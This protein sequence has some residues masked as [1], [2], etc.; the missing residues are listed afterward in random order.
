MALPEDDQDWTRDL[1]QTDHVCF[2]RTIDWASTP[3]GPLA[4]WNSTLRNFTRMVFADSRAACL[5]WCAGPDP[6]HDLIAI[7]ND[8]YRPLASH[9]HPKLM[10]ATFQEGY[11]DLWASIRVY[12]ERARAAGRGMDYSPAESLM[13]ERGGY[14]EEAFFNGNFVPIGSGPTNR[15]EGFYNSL[16]EVTSQRLADR[17]VSNPQYQHRFYGIG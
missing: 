16:V 15:P 14:R 17:R 5:W 2:F 7:Y 12:F 13:V 8:A 3:M 9:A 1:P 11:P 4:Q 6:D 10:G